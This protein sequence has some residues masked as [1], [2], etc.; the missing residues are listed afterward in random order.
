MLLVKITKRSVNVNVF[1]NQVIGVRL[2]EKT[3][4]KLDEIVSS[5]EASDRSEAVRSLLRLGFA[6]MDILSR[7]EARPT[8]PAGHSADAGPADVP[9]AQPQPKPSLWARIW[10][11]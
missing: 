10:G 11:I 5:G 1:M 6:S 9:E 8:A 2:D 3:I 7:L 4:S